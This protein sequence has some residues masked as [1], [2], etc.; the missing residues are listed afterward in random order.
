MDQNILKT[1]STELDTNALYSHQ[2]MLP[3][4][5]EICSLHMTHHMRQLVKNLKSH[6]SLVGYYGLWWEIKPVTF[7]SQVICPFPVPQSPQHCIDACTN[8]H[9]EACE[10]SNIT[11]V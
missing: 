8:M 4:D 11:N 9:N 5:D 10:H 1:P 7:C 2:C 3:Y 6:K